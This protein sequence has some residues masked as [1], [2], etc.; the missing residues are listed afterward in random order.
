[1]ATTVHLLSILVLF[2]LKQFLIGGAILGD[3]KGQHVVIPGFSQRDIRAAEAV[4]CDAD[5][6]ALNLLDIFFTKDVLST[7]LAT[8][9]EGHEVLDQDTIE[10]IRCKYSV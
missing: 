7:S 10:G 8:K 2:L 9:W 1:M 5:K 4:S 6:L 3:P